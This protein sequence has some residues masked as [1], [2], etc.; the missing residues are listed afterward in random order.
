LWNLVVIAGSLI[1]FNYVSAIASWPVT[2]GPV[3][4]VAI[5]TVGV[6]ACSVWAWTTE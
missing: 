1:D 5:M 2:H 3:W 6:M 4:L